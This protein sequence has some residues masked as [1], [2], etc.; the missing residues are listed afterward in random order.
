MRSYLAALLQRW[1][2]EIKEQLWGTWSTTTHRAYVQINLHKGM[3][4]L[5]EV[6]QKRSSILMH[7][8]VCTYENLKQ[9]RDGI[10]E[11]LYGT[12]CASPIKHYVFINLGE[13]ANDFKNLT[14]THKYLSFP[15]PSYFVVSSYHYSVDKKELRM[16]F[17]QERESHIITIREIGRAHV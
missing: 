15:L 1:E 12:S 7:P 2:E 9:W 6:K 11:K 13:S 4:V 8:E 16:S 5:N 14:I 17:L 3:E 10:R